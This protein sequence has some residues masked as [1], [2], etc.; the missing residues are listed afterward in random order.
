MHA[1]ERTEARILDA[2]NILVAPSTLKDE[3]LIRDFCGSVITLNDLS[4]GSSS[5]SQKTVY[6]CGDISRVSGHNLN[7]A[8]RIFVIRELSHGYNEED[9][10]TWTLVDLGR[11]PIKDLCAV[12]RRMCILPRRCVPDVGQRRTKARVLPSAAS[13][14]QR[15]GLHL[16]SDYLHHQRERHDA[17]RNY[18]S[19]PAPSHPTVW[20]RS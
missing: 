15:N 8:E 6:L 17:T 11:V 1:T 13:R 16:P 2:N 9:D 10:K 3:G 4:S 7:A 14:E 5:F 18:L 20:P 19:V 12:S